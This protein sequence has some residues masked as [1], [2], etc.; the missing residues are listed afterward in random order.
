MEMAL[1]AWIVAFVVWAGILWPH[2]RY[3]TPKEMKRRAINA[4]RR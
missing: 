3:V 2:N 1:G 4:L